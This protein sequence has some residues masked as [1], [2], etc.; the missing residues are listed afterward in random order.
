[1]CASA[2]SGAWNKAN[3]DKHRASWVRYRSKTGDPTMRENKDCPLYLGVHVA[4]RILAKVF[5][6]VERMPVNNVGYDFR[7]SQNKLIDVKSAT[8]N[9]NGAW[10]FH[11]RE[12]KIADYFLCLAFDNRED[13]TPLHLWLVPN[14]VLNRK[15]TTSISPS[16]LPRWKEY[17][18][19]IDKV[20]AC[21]DTIR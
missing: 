1:M 6:N 16:T 14:H 5:K 11:I 18:L 9:K 8:M 12:N 21:C 7:C 4:E 20:S 3:P 10:T 2:R 17:E 19:S 13:L 15:I